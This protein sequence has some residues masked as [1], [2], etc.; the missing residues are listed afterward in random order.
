[1]QQLA[2]EMGAGAGASGLD[3]GGAERT[4]DGAVDQTSE[5]A[6]SAELEAELAADVISWAPGSDDTPGLPEGQPSEAQA[7]ACANGAQSQVRCGFI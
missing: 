7:L 6:L 2:Q 5:G 4:A 3:A 1:M